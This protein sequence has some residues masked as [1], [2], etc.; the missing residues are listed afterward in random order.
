[1]AFPLIKMKVSNSKKEKE[2]MCNCN[3]R[4]TIQQL[5]HKYTHIRDHYN[6]YLA[7]LKIFFFYNFSLVSYFQTNPKRVSR[8]R[9]KKKEKKQEEEKFLDTRYGAARA[10]KEA[11]N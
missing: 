8:R 4:S 7:N 2:A 10:E 3:R 6:N 9:E 5:N 1:M 11:Q